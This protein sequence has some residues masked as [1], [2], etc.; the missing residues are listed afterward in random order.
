MANGLYSVSNLTVMNEDGVEEVYTGKVTIV[1]LKPMLNAGGT[2]AV[3]NSLGT[4]LID[5]SVQQGLDK[6]VTSTYQCFDGVL[7][8]SGGAIGGAKGRDDD[9]AYDKFY[10]GG[11][12]GLWYIPTYAKEVSKS[13][14]LAETL[15]LD[16]AVESGVI[17]VQRNQELASATQITIAVLNS[18]PEPIVGGSIYHNS[19]ARRIESY[20]DDG[21]NW[22]MTLNSSLAIVVDTVI[23]YPSNSKIITQGTQT[24]TD[25]IG[26]PA[27]DPQDF[28]NRLASGK[29]IDMNYLLVGEEGEDYTSSEE[30]SDVKLKNKHIEIL[31]KTKI[32]PKLLEM[33]TASDAQ[34]ND[35]FGGS[36]AIGEGK[37]VVGSHYEDT[38]GSDTGK[39]YVYDSTTYTELTTITASDAQSSDRF[40]SSVAI[41]E[42]K[43]VVGAAKVA[44]SV[45]KVYVYDSTTYAELTTITA[46]DAQVGNYFGV[47]V[48]IGEGKIV[49]GSHLED[50][51]GSNAGKVYIYDSTTYIELTTITASDAQS[52]YRFGSSV[53]IGEGKLVVGADSVASNNG[54]VYV[55]DAT[56]YA[57]LTTITASDAQSDD[58]FGVSVAIGEGKIVVGVHA[59]DTVAFNAGKVYIYDSTTYAQITTITASDAQSDDYFGAS[60]SIGEGK[61]IVGA[62]LE[63]TAGSNAGK[64]YIYSSI[65]YGTYNAMTTLTDDS[66]ANTTEIT[67]NML[68][69]YT[70]QN[71]PLVQ[72]DP[73]PVELVRDK[74]IAS[75]SH[76]I[77]K[78]AMITNFATNK[79]AVGNGSNGLESKVLENTIILPEWDF[80]I[81]SGSSI[82]STPTT[83]MLLLEATADFNAGDIVVYTA[84]D[85]T[86]WTFNSASV[87]LPSWNKITTTPSH[88]TLVLDNEVGPTSKWFRTLALAENNEYVVQVFTKELIFD[89]DYGDT[90]L[91]EQLI[92]GNFVDDNGNTVLTRVGIYP[93]GV[94]KGDL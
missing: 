36:V 76:S 58:Y 91:F 46:S 43:I 56:T 27:N 51:A 54:K 42:G 10:S 94:F 17:T 63:D 18:E 9:R 31:S 61:I 84:G 74:V 72:S 40:G 66:I 79:V 93:T 48:A 44:N 6:A 87:V 60:A 29:S 69:S 38:A 2:H 14:L 90:D 26:D 70:A 21:T 52:N 49:V 7:A 64:V 15:D 57:E 67:R 82:T 88:A 32:N 59:E 5:G 83:K 20:V 11:I 1:G 71:K 75:N 25:R 92:N 28:K 30:G 4:K 65:E 24:T 34:S 23:N 45:G 16:M 8:L 86:N 19:L 35:R 80:S 53:A 50:S 41:G 77:Y 12:G 68:V 37:I 33:L 22:V 89:V 62:L 78:D 39:V 85:L 73:L 47:S 55:L 81:G 13:D 3:Y